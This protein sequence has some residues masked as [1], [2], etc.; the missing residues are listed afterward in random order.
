MMVVACALLSA[1]SQSAEPASGLPTTKMRLGNRTFTLEIANTN[2]TRLRGLMFRDSM[3]KYHGMIFVFPDEQMLSFYM[4]NTKIPLDIIYLDAEG[5]IVSI[6]Q[7]QPYVERPAVPS[8]K[9]A[10]YAIEIN[11]GMAE[12]V[13]LKE[14]DV[15]E[16]P[17]EA[18]T[19]D[20]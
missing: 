3:P 4:K 5:R 18:R 17:P 9:P 2:Q 1:C 11:Q 19:A 12:A 7:M 10:Q 20:E 16:I 6:H 15:L 13:G 8:A 14:G